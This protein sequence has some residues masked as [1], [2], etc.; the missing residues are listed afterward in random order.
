MKRFLSI[1]LFAIPLS[2]C[3]AFLAGY[4]AGQQQA[5]TYVAPKPYCQQL[6]VYGANGA[7]GQWRTVC[8]N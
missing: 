3:E 6:F 8:G 5:P 7:P 1:C 4:T 2:G